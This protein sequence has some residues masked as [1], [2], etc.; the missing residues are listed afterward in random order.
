LGGRK[1]TGGDFGGGIGFGEG[2]LG[3]F[4]ALRGV[5]TGRG[6]GVEGCGANGDAGGA[7]CSAATEA[8]G[9]MSRL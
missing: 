6:A 8:V 5:W 4:W 3:T 1:E 7:A 2:E 9:T